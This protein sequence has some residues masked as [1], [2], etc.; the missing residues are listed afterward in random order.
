[1]NEAPPQNDR[2]SEALYLP[3]GSATG[4]LGKHES[5]C[6]GILGQHPQ[7]QGQE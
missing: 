6:V 3:G 5:L 4:T 7:K 2:P 1:M